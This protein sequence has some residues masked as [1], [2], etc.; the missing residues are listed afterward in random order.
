MYAVVS[1]LT[2]GIRDAIKVKIVKLLENR[3]CTCKSVPATNTAV[4]LE[5]PN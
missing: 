4:F 3:F 5:Q 2:T 1:I